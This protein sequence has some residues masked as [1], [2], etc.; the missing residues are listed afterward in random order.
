MIFCVILK[1]VCIRLDLQKW[2]HAIDQ[3]FLFLKFYFSKNK[4][5]I[6]LLI[7]RVVLK[8]CVE[9]VLHDLLFVLRLFRDLGLRH[10]ADDPA[11]F[12]RVG[13]PVG[14]IRPF[15]VV[16]QK[17]GLLGEVLR[18]FVAVR[19]VLTLGDALPLTRVVFVLKMF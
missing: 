7:F 13:E 12:L 17:V 14:Q 1:N 4:S 5:Q 16:E 9:S 11:A 8:D 19:I 10:L 2:C 3:I 6:F 15:D 18:H